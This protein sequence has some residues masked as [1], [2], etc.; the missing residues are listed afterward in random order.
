[1]A[2]SKKPALKR[3]RRLTAQEQAEVKSLLRRKEKAVRT[4]AAGRRP[5]GRVAEELR[6]REAAIN[7]RASGKKKLDRATRRVL[8]EAA[9]RIERRVR[10]RR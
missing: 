7:R 9:R 4:R 8:S 1:M 10:R 3:R 2:S 5:T 6:R